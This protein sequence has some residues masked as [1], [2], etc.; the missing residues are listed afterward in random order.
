ML[1]AMPR[2]LREAAG[3]VCYHV[4]N[5]AVGRMTI[6]ETPEDYAAFFRCV[7]HAKAS[8]PGVR[9]VSVVLMPN[10]FHMVLW[11]RED[12]EL[13][14]FMRLLSVTH[15]QRWHAHTK[16]AGTGPVYQGRFKS[17]PIQRDE[18][19][20]TV[21][22]YLDR[23]PLRAKLV[24]RAENWRHGSLWLGMQAERPVWLLPE[25]KWPVARAGDWL[26]WVNTPQTP[27]EEA[28]IQLC[29]K[30]GRPYGSPRW[31]TQTA[32]SMGLESSL[33]PRG[34]PAKKKARA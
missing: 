32:R 20:L 15:T 22:R 27:K 9:V 10:H 33:R 3:G 29:I 25:S 6:F 24:R 14:Q 4:L 21:L 8:V 23:N 12:G 18:H 11:P 2:Q 31:T 28:E 1:S 7:G 16:T 5:R 34:R 26:E 30:R 19:L 13:S 17:F